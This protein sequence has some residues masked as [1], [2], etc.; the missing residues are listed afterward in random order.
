MKYSEFATKIKELG[1]KAD[2]IAFEDYVAV[3][4]DGIEV[5]V[6]SKNY[7]NVIDTDYTTWKGLEIW[8]QKILFDNLVALAKT[9]LEER[10]DEKK[11]NVVA[12]RFKTGFKDSIKEQTNY[13][14][15]AQSFPW[16][17]LQAREDIFNFQSNQQW[18]LQ[19][20]H[21]WGLENYERIEV[22]EEG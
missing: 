21:E 18:T 3:Q 13:Y 16:P 4:C 5:A 17:K 9:P 22:E 12:C 10:G 6:V 11:Y 2:L 8:E 14:Y 7:I 15:R 20:I 1:L 19:Q